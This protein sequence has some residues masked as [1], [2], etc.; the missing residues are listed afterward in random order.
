MRR[1]PP[2]APTVLDRAIA[3]F[4]PRRAVERHRA[5]TMLAMTGGYT[6]ARRDRRQT[7]E[8]QTSHGSPDADLLPDLPTLRDRSRDMF[9]NLPLATGAVNTVVTSVVGTGLALQARID[10]DFLGLADDEADRWEATAERIWRTWADSQACDVR[11]IQNFAEMQAL[12]FR[13]V[14]LGGDAFAIRRFKERPDLAPLGFCWQLIE[15][16]RVTN[17]NFGADGRTAENGNRLVGGVETNA[18]GEPVAYHVL[19][20]HPGDVALTGAAARAW[21]RLPARTPAGRRIVQHLY[22]PSRPEQ[23]RGEPYLAPVIEH[24][25]MLGRYSEGELMAAV[26]G[27]MFTVFVKSVD[28]NGFGDGAGGGLAGEAGASPRATGAGDLKLGPGAILG[29]QPG[30]D[31][32]VA[33]PG[34]PNVAFDPFVTAILRQIGVALE[35]PFEILVKHFTASYSASQAA[36][37]EAWKYFRTCRGWLVSDFCRPTYEEVIGEAVARGMLAAPGFFDDPMYRAAWLGSSWAGPTRGQLDP[38][39]EVAAAKERVD[40]G[41]ST[42]DDE[43]AE[44]GRDWEQVHRQRVKEVGLRVEAGL[45][46]S[47]AA[48]PGT[49]PPGTGQA[50]PAPKAPPEPDPDQPERD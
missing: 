33:S 9:R 41:V 23:T 7:S 15:G 45:Q 17:P 42:L 10:R 8:W 49:A 36:M 12:A 20:R 48:P 25:K 50:A 35:L 29:L 4:D 2:V 14:L 13:S 47:P 27:G 26:V 34:R 3:W 1:L 32:S 16:D 38:G 22:R 37:L 44:L 24:L 39:K 18:D 6:G 46:P 21:T 43:A 31:V 11:G 30:E 28:A 5:R 40:L 19:D